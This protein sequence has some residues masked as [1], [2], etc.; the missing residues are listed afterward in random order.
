MAGVPAAVAYVESDLRDAWWVPEPMSPADVVRAYRIE[1]ERSDAY[2]AGAQPDN[3][4]RWWP[5]GDG[6]DRPA[7]LVEVTGHV[8]TEAATY[9]GHLDI[10]RELIDGRQFLVMP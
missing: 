1:D 6:E 3:A 5:D 2:L 9:V 4:P 7:D 8:L 10:V